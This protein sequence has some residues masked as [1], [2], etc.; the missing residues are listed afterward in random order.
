MAREIT[1]NNFEIS[2][3]VF[4]P[5]ITTDHAITYTNTLF[6]LMQLMLNNSPCEVFV[7]SQFVLRFIFLFLLNQVLL[8]KCHYIILKTRDAMPTDQTPRIEKSSDISF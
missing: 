1:N 5:N 6:L 8:G 4:M 2:L 3:V 7:L